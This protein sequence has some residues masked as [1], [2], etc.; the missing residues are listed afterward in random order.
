MSLRAMI[1]RVRRALCPLMG[2]ALVAAPTPALAAGKTYTVVMKAMQFGPMPKGLHVGDTIEWV[3]EDLFRHTA[4]ATDKSFNVDLN[5]NK[6]AKT[7]LRKAGKI[8]FICRFHPGMT[9]D[10]IVAR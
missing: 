10:L 3:N 5:P 4:T 1:A 6:R 8:H 7:V 9:G 2:A